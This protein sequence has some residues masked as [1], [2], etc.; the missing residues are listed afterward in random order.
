MRTWGLNHP[1]GREP[2]STLSPSAHIIGPLSLVSSSTSIHTYPMY[3]SSPSPPTAS[4]LPG[5]P[6]R[7][8]HAGVSCSFSHG[9]WTESV[10]GAAVLE[11]AALLGLQG[12]AYFIHPVIGL[13]CSL[14]WI[15]TLRP[16]LPSRWR[17]ART[18]DPQEQHL[19]WGHDQAGPAVD[20]VV[21]SSYPQGCF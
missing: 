13:P 10:S 6:L 8:V 16:S 4:P 12:T 1:P 19:E 21:S 14:V 17:L 3:P 7:P 5:N 20:P 9:H 11:R 15:C 18:R 2:V